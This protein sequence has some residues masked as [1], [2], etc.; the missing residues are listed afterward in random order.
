M[1][2][3]RYDQA[4]PEYEKVIVLSPDNEFAY[5]M[6]SLALMRL[7]RYG[8]A[9][10]ELE[11]GVTSFPENTDLA[12]SLARLLAACPDRSL[13]NG[14][15]ALRLAEKLLKSNPSPE[16]DLVETYGMALASVGRFT[17]AAD[18]QRRMIATLQSS[19]RGDLVAELTKN[20]GLYEHREASSVPWPDNDP[21]W[22]PEPGKMM[23]Q[24][25]KHY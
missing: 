24:V 7:H 12:T 13:R 5:L 1:R 10:H 3:R 20:L 16:F 15:A 11:T 17:E 25:P 21:I 4:L 9:K 22:A 8:E 19:K 14:P 18:L 2:N 23:L 6:K